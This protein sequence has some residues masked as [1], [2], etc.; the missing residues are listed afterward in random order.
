MRKLLIVCTLG[1]ALAVVPASAAG[2]THTGCEHRATGQAHASVP[3]RNHGT[4]NA[5]Q[6]IPYCPPEDAPR[7]R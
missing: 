4:H 6:S 3:H 2:A 7:H 1:T 5:H